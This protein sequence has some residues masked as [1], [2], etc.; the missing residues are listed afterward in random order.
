MSESATVTK[1]DGA[2][3]GIG[4]AIDKYLRTRGLVRA[5]RQSLVP[6]VWGEVV[7][8]WYRKHTEVVRVE[9][10]VVS[11][12]CDSPSRAQQLQLDSPSIVGAL[13][14]RLGPRTVKE[15]RPSSGG[16]VRGGSS[17]GSGAEMMAEGPSRAELDRIDLEPEEQQW[18]RERAGVVEGDELRRLV[19]AVLTKHCKALRWKQRHGY[20]PCKGCGVLMAPGQGRCKACDPGRIPAQGSSDVWQ[21]RWQD[22]KWGRWA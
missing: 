5:S 6:I 8:E 12:R 13:N 1:R 3:S 19:E 15:I 20:V 17:L 22:S 4:E 7:G 18:V 11:V 2:F 10:G 21:D 16:I 9:K 14:E